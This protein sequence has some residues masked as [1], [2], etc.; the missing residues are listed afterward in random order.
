MQ[1]FSQ[2][3]SSN[4]L[5]PSF[6]QACP[7]CRLTNIVRAHYTGERMHI[8]ICISGTSTEWSWFAGCRGVE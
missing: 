7:S 6:L 8:V 1:S 4:K 2:N 5:T 3:V